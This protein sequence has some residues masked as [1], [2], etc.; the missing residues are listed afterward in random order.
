MKS[1][2]LTNL[3]TKERARK[4]AAKQ[5]WELFC[6]GTS[7]RFLPGEVHLLGEQDEREDPSGEIEDVI[8][9]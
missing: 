2:N 9:L 8:F 1:Q 7:G 6:N 4:K 5:L 3:I